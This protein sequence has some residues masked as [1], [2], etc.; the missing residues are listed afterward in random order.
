MPG[1]SQTFKLS[2]DTMLME[3]VRDVVGRCLDPPERAVVL[4]V[5]E[6]SHVQALGRSQ[7]VLPVCPGRRGS[8]PRGYVRDGVASLVAALGMA[9]GTVI[10]A[11]V[12]ALRRR[13]VECREFDPGGQYAA[14]GRCQERLS[15]RGRPSPPARPSRLRGVGGCR[16]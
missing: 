11:V 4:C 2:M 7:P 1:R 12:G 13:R 3:K 14:A 16:R 5:G 6:K 8:A 15:G 9:T 10:G